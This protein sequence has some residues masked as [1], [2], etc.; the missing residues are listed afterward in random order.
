MNTITVEE[1]KKKLSDHY[2][3]GQSFDMRK[4]DMIIPPSAISSIKQP[5]IF[6][7]SGTPPKGY[8][9]YISELRLLNLYDLEGRRF[10]R[11]IETVIEW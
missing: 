8:A 11:M 9:I 6:V 3:R 5:V 1:I 2:D 7:L 4:M 10:R